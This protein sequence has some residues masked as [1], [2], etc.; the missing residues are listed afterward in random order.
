M[1]SFASGFIAENSVIGIGLYEHIDDGLFG[2]L[3]DFSHEIVV[4]FPVDA[5]LVDFKRG[6]IDNGRGTSRGFHRGIDH[7]MHGGSVKIRASILLSASW[8]T[9]ND[10]NERCGV[11]LCRTA[12]V[13]HFK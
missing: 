13:R 9:S 3:V 6:A 12:L 2:G 8:Q 4:T 10:E 5:Q 11:R 1:P 7:G